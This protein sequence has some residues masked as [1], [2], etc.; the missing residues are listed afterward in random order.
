VNWLV[1]FDN[2]ED[3]ELVCECW[4]SSPHGAILLTSRSKIISQGVLNLEVPAFTDRDGAQFLLKQI[5]QKNAPKEEVAAANELSML[6]GGFP[7]GLTLMAMRIRVQETNVQNYL[8]FYKQHWIRLHGISGEILKPYYMRGLSTAWDISFSALETESADATTLFGVLCLMASDDIPVDL[9]RP[10]QQDLLPDQL[11][12]CSDLW[13]Y[14]KYLILYCHDQGGLMVM[15]ECSFEMACGVLR[16]NSMVKNNA[17]TNALSV[18]RLVQIEYLR[19]AD[20]Q[21]RG[22]YL[23]L[24]IRLLRTAFPSL[25]DDLTLRDHWATCKEY[26]QHVSALATNFVKLDFGSQQE[27][28]ILEFAECLSSCAWYIDTQPYLYLC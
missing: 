7:L 3:M 22:K 2:V 14:V 13:R 18:H 25:G 19:R 27:M 4:P 17:D 16:R 10:A 23:E 28:V 1:V 21:R 24:A 20:T 8:P 12:F 9:F 15:M 6:L 26:V 5:N 11:S